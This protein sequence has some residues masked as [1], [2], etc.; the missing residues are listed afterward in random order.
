MPVLGAPGPAATTSA[1]AIGA[2]AIAVATAP[3]TTSGFMKL[4]FDNI[5]VAYHLNV[6][7]NIALNSAYPFSATEGV[8]R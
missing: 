3:A 5:H 1:E 6:Y 7:S 4:N 2:A 8:A